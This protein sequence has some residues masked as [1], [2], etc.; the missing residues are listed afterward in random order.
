MDDLWIGVHG[1]SMGLMFSFSGYYYGNPSDGFKAVASSLDL[2][3]LR[4]E[5]GDQIKALTQLVES[6]LEVGDD[7]QA[8]RTFRYDQPSRNSSGW[9]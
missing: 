1:A 9:P 4:Q 3:G 5:T 8:V 7:F 2:S 6:V